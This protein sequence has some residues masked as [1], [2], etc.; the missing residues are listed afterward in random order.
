MVTLNRS[1]NITFFRQ[2]E[3]AARESWLSLA[4]DTV[5]STIVSEEREPV[6]FEEM[7]RSEA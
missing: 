7:K 5:E 6:L 4:R 1:L 2:K 3:L